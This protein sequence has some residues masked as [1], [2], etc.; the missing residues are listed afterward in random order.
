MSNSLT[1]LY[2]QN[3]E[4]ATALRKQ[5]SG[6]ELM[7]IGADA[8]PVQ[9][10][11]QGLSRLAAALVGGWE[12]GQADKEFK[13]YGAAQK[14]ALADAVA[15]DRA[16]AGGGAAPSTAG[17][18]PASGS[19]VQYSPGTTP[20]ALGP[21]VNVPPQ[22]APLVDAASTQYGV[23]R[24]I[25]A[26][27]LQ[28]E[29]S[30]NPTAVNPRS[31]ATGMAQILGST[32]AQ[33][34]Y[35]V[36]ALAPGDR[37]DP[38]KA[39]PWIAQYMNARFRNMG[40]NDWNNPQQVGMLLRGV[41]ENTPAYA[42]RVMSRAGF[43]VFSGG[44]DPTTG[45]N[46]GTG[47]A[48]NMPTPMPA[49]G[50][51]PGQ[52]G[53][54]PTGA[55]APMVRQGM[56]L[57]D[58]AQ[59]NLMSNNQ[60]LRALGQVQMEKAK[61]LM[62]LDTFVDLPGGGQRN[63]RTGQLSYPPAQRFATTS[64]GTLITQDAFGRIQTVAP[65]GAN[66]GVNADANAQRVLQTY[67]PN[68]PEYRQAYDHLYGERT[69]MTP[70][71][72]QTYRPRQPPQGLAPP[73]VAAPAPPPAAAAAQPAQAPRPGVTYA[74][75][76]APNV[77][78]A[79]RLGVPLAETN[80]YEGMSA[81]DQQRA[82]TEALKRAQ[83]RDDKRDEASADQD[84][85]MLDLRRF[86]EL[87]KQAAT[88]AW[89]DLPGAQTFGRMTSSQFQE[90]QAIASENIP[91]MRAVGSGTS[92][93]NDVRM[94]TQASFGVNKDRAVNENI[95]DA[96]LIAAENARAKRDFIRNYIEVNG[97]EQG[98]DRLWNMY[99]QAN[100][101]FDPKQEETYGLNK[102][103]VNWETWFKNAIDPQTGR[104]KAPGTTGGV[105]RFDRNGNP[106]NGN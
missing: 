67:P 88:G 15:R 97:H 86:K 17:T 103:R 100:P 80:P 37:N 84:K 46:T 90:M 33:P 29:S 92:S 78:V 91:K 30:W 104:M 66:P 48:I 81:A 23:P 40:F 72:P 14:A 75:P 4:L 6:R 74:A 3:P 38:N 12:A 51:Q 45:Q 32:A 28:N 43:P 19:P 24:H 9:H 53:G 96:T 93:D 39:I 13:D 69:E 27:Y 106:I 65:G 7:R 1:A 26:A 57:M 41:G 58:E 82:R 73:V 56:V 60:Q 22:Y 76:V 62:G 36:P 10:W 8:S 50:A 83:E 95:I 87:N 42:D 52:P 85:M 34:G 89:Y 20:G 79:R 2:L 55:N 61:L 101:I 64:D 94:F 49:A 18:P 35:G 54:V 16:L 71:G 102:N 70:S 105:M 68:T 47:M 25:L 77:E 99:L 31:G 98:A 59:R 11:A 5:E 44:M 21:G 63:A